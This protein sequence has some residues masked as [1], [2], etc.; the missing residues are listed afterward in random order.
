MKSIKIL[1]GLFAFAI[2][3]TFTHAQETTGKTD[4]GAT[5]LGTTTVGD[6]KT[7]CYEL[8]VS[9]EWILD[10]WAQESGGNVGDTLQFDF[11]IGGIF[12]FN[13]STGSVEYPVHDVF[14]VSY[15]LVDNGQ[16]P[17]SVDQP[18]TGAP[19]G[20]VDPVWIMGSFSACAT[21][22]VPVDASFS[23][24]W[25]DGSVTATLNG[26]PVSGFAFSFGS[27]MDSSH[28]FIDDPKYTVTACPEATSSML[29]LLGAATLVLRRR[30]A[31]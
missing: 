25:K 24:F 18:V 14:T 29:G 27:T 28:T 19:D 30:R 31:A 8:C 16:N 7:T 17:S 6:V 3:S 15:T 12:K 2:G 9:G 11:S 26:N 13:T 21:V 23:N 4:V 22:D 5:E 10:Y 20:L 1:V